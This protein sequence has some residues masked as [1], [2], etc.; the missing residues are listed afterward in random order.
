MP[1]I[2]I[3]LLGIVA[4]LAI[5]FLLSTGKRRIKLRVVGAAF[6]LQAFMATDDG[7][8]LHAAYKRAANILKKEEGSWSADQASEG[9]IEAAEAALM[10]A[11]DAAGPKAAAALEEED[12]TGAME[13]LSLLR[14]PID[15]FFEDVIVNAED[16]GARA[17]RLALLERFRNAVGQVA[18]FSKVEG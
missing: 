17:R 2:V 13:A 10:S 12:F 14:A 18:D 16:A 3:N 8:N 5:A 6:A 1:P 11:L 15:A 7:A 4:I 9:E